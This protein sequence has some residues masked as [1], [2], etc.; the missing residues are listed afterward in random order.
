MEQY[1]TVRR[2]APPEFITIPSL[3]RIL[4]PP[5]AVDGVD[6]ERTNENAYTVPFSK[7]QSIVLLNAC[8][9]MKME[10]TLGRRDTRSRHS[11]DD[12]PEP[13]V[14]EFDSPFVDMRREGIVTGSQAAAWGGVRPF[15]NF[16]SGPAAD[17]KCAPAF[18]LFTTAHGNRVVCA[19]ASAVFAPKICFVTFDPGVHNKA[20]PA[21]TEFKR[22]EV[23]V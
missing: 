4:G 15:K 18:H 16:G 20:F 22:E 5:N 1:K 3:Y 7:P 2:F 21:H 9:R 12:Y 8:E 11:V 17:A 23:A 19:G 10:V 13:P 14:D 6:A